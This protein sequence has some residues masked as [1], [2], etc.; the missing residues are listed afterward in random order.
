MVEVG[1]LD[2]P[3]Y[4]GA[5]EVG[6]LAGHVEGAG[7]SEAEHPVVWTVSPGRA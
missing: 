3:Q 6:G 2:R 1:S 7:S 4:G 5:E